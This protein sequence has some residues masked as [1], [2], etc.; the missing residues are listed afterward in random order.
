MGTPVLQILQSLVVIAVTPLCSG[1]LARAE[2]MGSKRDP[3]GV[4]PYQS[5]G[6]VAAQFQRSGSMGVPQRTV[7]GVR[8]L[9][10]RVGDRAHHHE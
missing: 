10:Y 1:I 5:S 2:A 7:R 8:V 4:Q 3:S 9:P 6:E